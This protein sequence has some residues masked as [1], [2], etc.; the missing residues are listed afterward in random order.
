MTK[1]CGTCKVE[2]TLSE[3][4]SNKSKRD[5]K[6]S[7]CIPCKREYDNSYYKKTPKRRIDIRKKNKQS[8]ARNRLAVLEYLRTSG[9]CVD[10]P[11]SDPVVLEFDHR[12]DKRF[13]IADALGESYSISTL[14]KEI[15]KCD[16]RCA[17]CH[18]RKTAR[19]QGHFRYGV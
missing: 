15:A 2:K 17:N 9:G 3:F 14:M 8:I 1:V 12:E 6:Q 5:G 13:N 18:R 4:G 7:K 19:T 10:C 11:E 16:V